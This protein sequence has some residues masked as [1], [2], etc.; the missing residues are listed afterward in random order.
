[1]STFH[2]ALKM[3]ICRLISGVFFFLILVG[4]GDAAIQAA[5]I[6]VGIIAAGDSL[7]IIEPDRPEILP[8]RPG[9]PIGAEV[10]DMAS[11]TI[12][13]HPDYFRDV[14]VGVATDKGLM[15]WTPK[16]MEPVWQFKDDILA[17]AANDSAWVVVKRKSGGASP[18]VSQLL[19]AKTSQLSEML[20]DETWVAGREFS[21]DSPH[22]FMGMM[23]GTWFR[24][25]DPNVKSWTHL[26]KDD[27]LPMAMV[28][29][30]IG[31]DVYLFTMPP[32]GGESMLHLPAV[33]GGID[34]VLVNRNSVLFMKQAVCVLDQAKPMSPSIQVLGLGDAGNGLLKTNVLS[35]IRGSCTTGPQGRAYEWLLASDDKL[36]VLE[37]P[38]PRTWQKTPPKAGIMATRKLPGIF[39][40][41]CTN[42]KGWAAIAYWV[43]DSYTVIDI[44]DPS[45]ETLTTLST[46]IVWGKV[47]AMVLVH[48]DATLTVEE[49]ATH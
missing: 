6:P 10:R 27:L 48:T 43:D 12:V 24:E 39:S 2:K 8:P 23:Q 20:L 18:P 15:L 28:T 36:T 37:V 47:K 35:E 21:A 29:N 40:A 7:W 22:L 9:I 11:Q 19:S 16:I 46:S 38:T 3:V 45:D 44:F 5:G 13:R 49:Y 17:V 25:I 32:Y 34:D 31:N 41:L 4:L 1:M 33:P 30:L 42:G 14:R 26:T